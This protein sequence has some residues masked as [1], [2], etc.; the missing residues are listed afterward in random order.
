MRAVLLEG[1]ALSI[2]ERQLDGLPRHAA[3]Q[4][5]GRSYSCSTQLS[6]HR[7]RGRNHR[8]QAASAPDALATWVAIASIKAGERQS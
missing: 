7:L 1:A 5:T 3:G 4:M 6:V 2:E 8:A